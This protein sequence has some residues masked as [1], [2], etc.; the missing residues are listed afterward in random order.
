[1]DPK[2]QHKSRLS[3]WAENEVRLAC[4]HENPNWN[5]KSFDYGCSCYGAA[6]KVYETMCRQ[7]H[8]GYSWSVTANIVE[9]LMQNLPLTP[10]TIEDFGY[11]PGVT[12]ELKDEKTGAT[13]A[14]GR[15]PTPPS[16]SDERGNAH[17]QCPRMSSLF[18]TVHPDKTYELSDY[19]RFVSVNIECLNDTYSGG[20]GRGIGEEMFPISFPYYP[21][22]GH[23]LIYTRTFLTDPANG[24][25]DTVEIC[26]IKTPD[27]KEIP[28]NRY[29][30]EIDHK[31]I[32]IT[33]EDY[34]D[35]SKKRIDTFERNVT[36]HIAN[37]IVE[38]IFDQ[39][40]SYWKTVM[41]DKWCPKYDDEEYEK[42]KDYY[43]SYEYREMWWAMYRNTN[44]SDTCDE[45]LKKLDEAVL[46]NEEIH[47][48]SL[49]RW[50]VYRAIAGL[51]EKLLKEHPSLGEVYQATNELIK[52]VKTRYDWAMELTNKYIKE[53]EAIEDPNMR[54][55]RR[56]QLIEQIENIDDL[57]NLE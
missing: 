55:E 4:Q 2:K 11:I 17:Y 25:F 16:W 42:N 30:H 50:G 15:I 37:D 26:Y 7:G 6:L 49:C 38:S 3:T 39:G 46:A 5:G 43:H 40:E 36:S 48:Q 27:G 14:L 24:D 56:K 29:F 13:L 31:M 9:R 21:G 32:E 1:M 45:L 20:V 19:D 22:K 10:I 18:L 47:Q 54:K 8:S 41:D 33:A 53:L 12:P 57:I 23:Y 34:L 51:D 28:V 44:K 35:V 52:W